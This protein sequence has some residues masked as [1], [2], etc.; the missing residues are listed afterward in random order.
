MIGARYQPRARGRLRADLVGHVVGVLFS[1]TRAEIGGSGAEVSLFGNPVLIPAL[2]GGYARKLVAADSCYATIV[3]QA[4]MVDF[5]QTK[6]FA[7]L[8]VFSVDTLG[9]TTRI[10]SYR[11]AASSTGIQLGFSTNSRLGYWFGSTSGSASVAASNAA[12]E[13]GRLYSVVFGWDSGHF[14]FINGLRQSGASPATFVT[15][16]AG[17]NTDINIG[18]RN[19]GGSHLDGSVALFAHIDGAVDGAALSLDPWQMF[20]GGET[21]YMVAAAVDRAI[22]VTPAALLLSGGDVAMRVSRRTAVQSAQLELASADVGVR[23]SRKIDV[24][25]AGVSFAG[26]QVDLRAARRFPVSAAEMVLQAGA[27]QLRAARRLV[28][29]PATASLVGGSIELLHTPGESD[30]SYSISVTPAALVL[31]AGSVNMRIGRRIAAGPAALTLTA[32][33]VRVLAAR[34]L[35][36]G[37]A[38]LQ[39][40]AGQALLRA[41]RLLPVSAAQLAITGSTVTLH[42]S[43][44]VEYT[45]APTGP[46]YSPRRVEVQA[47]PAQTQTVAGRTAQLGGRRPASI[48]RN[49]R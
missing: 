26:G 40:V 15:S 49:N 29:A 24:Q 11:H 45:R 10:L 39:A 43:S 19:T 35:G 14:M 44:Q 22:A 5:S 33:D 16:N 8:C 18:R 21:D 32:G 41:T 12:L 48:Q 30:S 13:P 25:S 38:A 6:P 2:G 36:V 9:V 46:G 34:R 37:A 20:E 42:Y 23:A 7:V 31:G 27:A 4:G 17:A 3:P 1:N 47:R 28:V